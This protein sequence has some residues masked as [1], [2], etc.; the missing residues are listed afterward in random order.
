M[1]TISGSAPPLYIYTGPESIPEAVAAPNSLE[2]VTLK[3]SRMECVRGDL[4]EAD[5]SE[6]VV[7]D[8][9]EWRGTNSRLKLDSHQQK[10][11]F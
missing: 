8:C 5:V 10:A 2:H 6:T 7:C 11:I 4:Q 3:K 1:A 9:A